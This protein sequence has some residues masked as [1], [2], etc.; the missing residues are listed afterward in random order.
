MVQDSA[1]GRPVRPLEFFRADGTPHMLSSGD[2]AAV[3]TDAQGA[4][5]VAFF[6]V[7]SGQDEVTGWTARVSAAGYE[8]ETIAVGAVK[9]PQRN[10]VTVY[11]VFHV[12]LRKAR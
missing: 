9:E 6:T 8:Q 3:T 10:D 7:P 1:D 11:L 2:P 4:F 5:Q 12:A